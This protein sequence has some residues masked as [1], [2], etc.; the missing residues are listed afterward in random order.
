MILCKSSRLRPYTVLHRFPFVATRLKSLNCLTAAACDSMDIRNSVSTLSRL[1]NCTVIEGHLHV[2]LTDRGREADLAN[3]SFPRLREITD[4][5]LLYR[6]S[7]LQSL[8]TLFPNLS[9]IRGQLLL[10]NYALVVFEM[11]DMRNIGL[12][13]LM[14]IT[15]GSVRYKARNI[16]RIPLRLYNIKR[17][18]VSVTYARS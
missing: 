12:V 9:V 13:N 1:R 18:K 8:A 5:L 17:G 3:V 16:L 14:Q 15:A 10:Y 4:Y 2:V 7:G 11:P 6:V